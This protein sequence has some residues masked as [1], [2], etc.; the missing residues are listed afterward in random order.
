MRWSR[1]ASATRRRPRSSIGSLRSTPSISASV[2][3]ARAMAT[4]AVPVA[5]SRMRSGW[6]WAMWRTSSRLHLPFWPSERTSARRSYRAG[7]GSKRSAAKA[8]SGLAM[9]DLRLRVSVALD[10]ERDRV[11]ALQQG[12]HLRVV[13]AVGEALRGIQHQRQQVDVTDAVEEDAGPAENPP[14]READVVRRLERVVPGRSRVVLLHPRPHGG[15]FDGLHCR[16]S[17]LASPDEGLEVLEV[18]RVLH[19]DEV[20]GKQH[21]VEVEAIEAAT[22]RGRDLRA[23]PGDADEP[24]EP[25]L[26]R[27]K[28]GV[29]RASRAE[30][31]VPLDRV[32]EGMQLPQVD[33]VDAKTVERALELFARAFLVALTGLGGEEE[34]TR[35]ALEPGR[36]A[37]L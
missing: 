6:K 8:F 31:L 22:V 21:R 1:P 12:V 23:V 2:A 34:V 3:C 18:I 5:T 17:L 10:E 32:R 9:G 15:R 27:D 20:V 14:H 24:D 25:L 30:S 19:R 4:A 37:E 33:V 29:E 13:R 16:L 7:S 28:G 35:L 11:C 36:D 26:A